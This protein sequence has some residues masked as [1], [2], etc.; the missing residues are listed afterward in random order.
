VN[1][2]RSESRL[3]VAFPGQDRPPDRFRIFLLGHAPERIAI[4]ERVAGIDPPVQWGCLLPFR[5]D[6]PQV[7]EAGGFIQ[8]GP[9]THVGIVVAGETAVVRVVRH[10]GAQIHLQTPPDLLVD[11]QAQTLFVA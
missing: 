11:V 7:E 1:V 2:A 10:V 5:T 6:R 9:I 4:G 3:R 8:R